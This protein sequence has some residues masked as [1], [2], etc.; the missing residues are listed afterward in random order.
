MKRCRHAE[1]ELDTRER[2]KSPGVCDGRQC[3]VAISP[4]G[5]GAPAEVGPQR[6]VGEAIH[7]F[8]SSA[9]LHSAPK[10][11]AGAELLGIDERPSECRSVS[12]GAHGNSP[13]HHVPFVSLRR[14][15]DQVLGPPVPGLPVDPLAGPTMPLSAK[16]APRHGGTIL[17]A[18]RGRHLHTLRYGSGNETKRSKEGASQHHLR[19]PSRYHGHMRRTGAFGIFL[20]AV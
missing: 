6:H 9:L 15:H 17:V 13:Q 3:A 8:A 12:A 20:V 1:H 2:G 11:S 19:G 14:P 5:P 18:G 4:A 16:D 7:A 10:S